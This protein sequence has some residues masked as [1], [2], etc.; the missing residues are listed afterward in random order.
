MPKSKKRKNRNTNIN[1]RARKQIHSNTIESRKIK[2]QLRNYKP[3]FTEFQEFLRD[4]NPLMFYYLI[5]KYE[6]TNL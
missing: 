1:H 3:A 4:N 6:K 2:A 5:N